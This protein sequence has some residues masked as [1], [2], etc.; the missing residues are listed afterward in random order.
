MPN[1]ETL[2]EITK[3]AQLDEPSLVLY[4]EIKGM[5]K[6]L[7]EMKADKVE[8]EV[9]TPVLERLNATVESL[10]PL[11]DKDTD[12]TPIATILGQILTQVSTKEEVKDRTDELLNA[13]KNLDLKPQIT[14]E[15]NDVDLTGIQ[16][17]LDKL[18]EKE[19]Q[20]IPLEE[21]R[22]PVKLSEEDL[23]AIGKA[24]GENVRVVGG[25]S[26]FSADIYTRLGDNLQGY[27]I[28]G[29]PITDTGYLYIG[30]EDK[31]GN[32]YIKRRNN[33]TKDWTYCKG[34]SGFST[35]WT[36]KTS[37]TYNSYSVIF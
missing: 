37:Q 12:L 13:L 5:G 24:T 14:V 11:L 28:M 35:A 3:V 1:K 2:E 18:I 36:A 9:L 23:K 26:G 32:W 19:T 8:P 22:V 16:E 6:T 27:Q 34:S 21:G 10:L 25:G 31:D 7:E 4:D 15:Q 33:T 30:K 20:E 29:G 17:R